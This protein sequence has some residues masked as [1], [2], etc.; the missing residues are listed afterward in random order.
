LSC[1]PKWPALFALLAIASLPLALT[2][3][4]YFWIAFGV[5]ALLLFL[6]WLRAKM[7]FLHGD[8][9]P[10]AIVS[11]NPLLLAVLGDLSMNEGTYP[12]VKIQRLS[13]RALFPLEPVIGTK[14]PTIA[15]YAPNKEGEDHWQDFMPKPVTCA[16]NEPAEVERVLKSF[17][18]DEWRLLSQYLKRVPQPFEPGLYPMRP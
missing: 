14:I 9:N 17:S 2:L 4:P 1:Y 15:L 7:Q 8:A 6:H 10:A 13:R 5:G 12:V 18:I 16:T 3:N 11:S